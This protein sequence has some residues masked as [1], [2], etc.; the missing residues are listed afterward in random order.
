MAWQEK[1][2]HITD[3]F[4]DR[5]LSPNSEQKS[6]RKLIEINRNFHKL[7]KTSQRA[8]ISL[9]EEFK[10][11]EFSFSD[12]SRIIDKPNSQSGSVLQPLVRLK[13]ILATPYIGNL[14]CK[15]REE[16]MFKLNKDYHDFFI[17]RAIRNIT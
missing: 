7:E 2:T 3:F 14:E 5:L 9:F 16:Q 12:F 11:G 10:V 15:L 4:R 13:F 8:I 17:S 6:N 1:L